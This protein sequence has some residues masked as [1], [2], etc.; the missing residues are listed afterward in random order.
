MTP[1]EMVGKL[2]RW[3]AD[4]PAVDFDA[5]FEWPE[6][7]LEP[8]RERFPKVLGYGEHRCVCG[9]ATKKIGSEWWCT[10]H[11]WHVTRTAEVDR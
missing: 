2:R 3:V 9:G 11:R 5:P 1:E 10:N 4:Q 6:E 7:L 8:L